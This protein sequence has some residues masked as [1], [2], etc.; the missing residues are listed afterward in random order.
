LGVWKK[1]A[2]VQSMRDGKLKGHI[3]MHKL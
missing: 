2:F 3:Y 1:M